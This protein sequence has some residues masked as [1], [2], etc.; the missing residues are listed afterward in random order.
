MPPRPLLK[1]PPKS[2]T[3]LP[4]GKAP[5]WLELAAQTLGGMIGMP[6]LSPEDY[7][8]PEGGQSID[9]A[10]SLG[11]MLGMVSPVAVLGAVKGGKTLGDLIK[12]IPNPIK[13]YHG[14]PHDF[15]QFSLSKIGTGEGAQ[16]YGHGLYFAENE[17]TA[18]A[19]RQ[20]LAKPEVWLGKQRAANADDR[21]EA[22]AEAWVEEAATA[23]DGGNPFDRAIRRIEETQRVISPSQAYAYEDA[24]VLIRRWKEQGAEVRNAGRTYEVNIHATPDELLDWDK[25]LSEQSE[26]VRKAIAPHLP[27]SDEA[28]AA[29]VAGWGSLIEDFRDPSRITGR[30]AYNY[31][32]GSEGMVGATRKLQEVPIN[33]TPVKGIQYLD[34]GS[35]GNASLLADAERGV[36]QVQQKIEKLKASGASADRLS[37]AM[38]ELE[39]AQRAVKEMSGT[40]NFVIF[41]DELI[42]IKRKFG[43]ATLAAAAEWVRQQ[44]GTVEAR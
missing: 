33:Q 39:S 35:R 10:G 25:P 12:R 31:L 2:D 17:G 40:R 41:D 24:K 42:E 13:A 21:T 20:V 4:R 22:M 6:P 26:I 29:R 3:P 32:A 9:R 28:E 16:A 18:K 27:T 11:E 43:F 19:Y 14:S 30:E 37:D 5:G 15:D 38:Q 1:K 8:T 44:G 23:A 7:T 36:R 34:Q